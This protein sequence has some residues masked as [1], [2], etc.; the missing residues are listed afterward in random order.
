MSVMRYTIVDKVDTVSFIAPPNSL[1]ALIAGCSQKPTPTTLLKLLEMASKYD[2]GLK[3]YVQDGLAIFDEHNTLK[4]APATLNPTFQR[5]INDLLAKFD[6]SAT[7]SYENPAPPENPLELTF[8][9]LIERQRKLRGAPAKRHPVLRVSDDA[10]RQESLEPIRFG[11]VIFNLIAKRIVQVQ[12]SYG[13]LQR[14]DRGRYFEGGK[15][16]DQTYWYR[17]PTDWSLLP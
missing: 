15:P 13:L 3:E 6:E 5:E 11:L 4:D 12:N 2:A 7:P 17:L 8:E 9:E 16:T 14:S 1:K 10:T